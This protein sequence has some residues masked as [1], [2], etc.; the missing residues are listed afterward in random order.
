MAIG[1]VAPNET[2]L[3]REWLETAIRL[4]ESVEWVRTVG[5]AA[6]NAPAHIC[7]W[8]KRFREDGGNDPHGRNCERQ[9]FLKGVK[10]D[11]GIG[12]EKE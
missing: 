3:L 2:E 12:T 6:P 8:C 5:R 1:E 11:L 9:H 4:I 7:P 10:R